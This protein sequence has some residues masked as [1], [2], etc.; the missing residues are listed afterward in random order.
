MCDVVKQIKR[1]VRQQRKKTPMKSKNWSTMKAKVRK[2]TGRV[3]KVITG[4]QTSE[5]LTAEQAFSDPAQ[6][7]EQVLFT[8]RHGTREEMRLARLA[9]RQWQVKRLRKR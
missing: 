3:R 4:R 9:Y 7:R 2:I 8:E 1:V 5:I 6:T